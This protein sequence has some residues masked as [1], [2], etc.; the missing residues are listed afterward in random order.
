[1]A[2]SC[3][4]EE[5]PGERTRRLLGGGDES[6]GGGLNGLQAGVSQLDF[7]QF[8][9]RLNGVRTRLRLR[10]GVRESICGEQQLGMV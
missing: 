4:I 1:M 6:E 5:R 7:R 10:R 3:S 8:T 9:H 2:A